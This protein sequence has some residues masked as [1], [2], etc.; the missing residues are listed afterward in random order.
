MHF[1]EFEEQVFLVDKAIHREIPQDPPTRETPAP[2]DLNEL[3]ATV[4]RAAED[5]ILCTDLDEGISRLRR[6]AEAYSAIKALTIE[7][8]LSRDDHRSAARRA[9]EA[10]PGDPKAL[11]FYPYCSYVLELCNG[12]E[13]AEHR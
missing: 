3:R 11:P 13:L 6:H 12:L 5:L 10:T 1:G 7:A 9:F 8:P 4:R 2:R